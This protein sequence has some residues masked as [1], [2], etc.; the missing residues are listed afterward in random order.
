MLAA[1]LLNISSNFH[2]NPSFCVFSFPIWR[3]KQA[4]YCHFSHSMGVYV[5]IHRLTFLTERGSSKLYSKQRQDCLK[6]A[7]DIISARIHVWTFTCKNMGE[8]N[9]KMKNFQLLTWK[10]FRETC[11]QILWI[12]LTDL[13]GVAELLVT[14]THLY[15]PEL[16]V[17]AYHAGLV[18]LGVQLMLWVVTGPCIVQWGCPQ[19]RDRPQAQLTGGF[20]QRRSYQWF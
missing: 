15:L 17:K 7:A 6:R 2:E 3:H 16:N 11:W 13:A 10:V 20:G 14:C 5:F 8:K 9:T 19:Q 18:W 4:I 1:N 12:S